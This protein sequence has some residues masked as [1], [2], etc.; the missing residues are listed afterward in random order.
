MSLSIWR[1]F[2]I[3]EQ[4]LSLSTYLGTDLCGGPLAGGSWQ[5]EAR[6]SSKRRNLHVG[7]GA[8]I[9]LALKWQDELDIVRHDIETTSPSSLLIRL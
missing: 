3:I 1:Q 9:S 5:D 2:S 4:H 7:L 6:G 8:L